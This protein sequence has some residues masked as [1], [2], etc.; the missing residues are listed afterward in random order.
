MRYSGIVYRPPSEG[1]SL[2][3]QATI[4]CS[5]NKCTFCDMYKDK[6]F[7]VRKVED[8]LQ[9]FREA[10]SY[11]PYVRRIFLA[12][13][14]ALIM[15]TEQLVQILEHIQENF[16]EC[17]RVAVY[18]SPY[19]IKSKTVE[20]LK[21]LHQKGLGIGYIGL[22]SGS[23]RILKKINKN[24]TSAE[25]IECGLKLKEAGIAVSVTAIS[26][27]GG[28]EYWREHAVETGK[29]FSAMN[30]EY[31]GLLTL[32]MRG[33]TPLKKGFEEGKFHILTPEEIMM[34]SMLMLQNIDSPGTI[35]RS[36]H[37]SN[38]V[39]LYGTLNQDREK[40]IQLLQNAMDECNFRPEYFRTL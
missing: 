31:I 35:L 40:M 32:F 33:D 29:A 22:E 21:L 4:G 24:V 23:D 6:V 2:I 18:A 20:E 14:D 27:L 26:G 34:E 13:G 17:E 12:D 37:V 15:K 7:Q 8:I 38:Y 39:N 3:V 28:I 10:R 16:P 5:H 19:S 25:T 1:R 36:N 9:D 11:Y 30:P